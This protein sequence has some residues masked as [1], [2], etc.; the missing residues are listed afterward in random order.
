[1]QMRKNHVRHRFWAS[2]IIATALALGGLAARAAQ[3]PAASEAS[4]KVPSKQAA[5]SKCTEPTAPTL[6][7][8]NSHAAQPKC[9]ESKNQAS[10]GQPASDQVA[11]LK[12][13]VALQQ[14]QIEQLARTVE[15]LKQ[16]M[17]TNAQQPQQALEKPLEAD[18]VASLTPII[19]VSHIAANAVDPLNLPNLGGSAPNTSARA[20]APQAG[21]SESG[22]ASPLSFRIG[23]A[24]FT[25]GGFMDFTSIYRSTNS[26][27]IGTSFGSI[28]F[29][30]TP[31]GRLSEERFSVQNSRISLGVTSKVGENN[32]KGYV[33][34]DFLGNQPTN[35]FVSSNSQTFRM[36]LYWVDVKRHKFEVLAGQSWTMMTPNRNGLSAEPSDIFYTQ[37]MDTNYQVGLTW[38][39]QGQIRFIYHPSNTVALGV[40]LENPQQFVGGAV[41][42]PSTFNVNQVDQGANVNTPNLHPDIIGKIAF[43]PMVS[44]RHMHV[45]VAGLLSSFR[46]FN[47]AIN[48]PVTST[49]GGGSVNFNLELVKNFHLIMNSFYSD[50]GGRYIFGLGPDFIVKPNGYLS[51]VHASSGLGGFEYQATPHTMLYGYYGGAY[52]D[53]NTAIDPAT[54]KYL[55]FGYP[56]SSNLSNKSVQ[57]GTFGIIQTFWKNPRYGALQLI[58]QYSYLTRAPWFIA[59]NTPKNAHASLGYVDLRYVLP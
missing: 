58:T 37:D 40:S 14:Q 38:A 36:R 19:P 22:Q 28:P 10:S 17:G 45:E 54:G 18:Q 5:N 7:N 15:E 59:P 49:G 2:G 3:T 4:T 50:G 57:E 44:G 26:G 30:N 33:E 31:Q 27:G 32:V 25:P 52:F 42:L 8:L 29:S 53:R 48:N 9:E 39:R 47:P 6:Q 43:D 21:G 55:G 13:Q 34:A 16:H 41:T 12:Q 51:L 56:G 24:D 46:V 1:M 11:A 20:A 23:D 35:A